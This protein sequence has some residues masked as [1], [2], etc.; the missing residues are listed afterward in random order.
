M[1]FRWTPVSGQAGEEARKAP[2]AP[3]APT[4]KPAAAAS[5]DRQTRRGTCGSRVHHR[6]R[7]TR[8]A[9]H[10]RAGRVGQPRRAA[11]HQGTPGLRR[12]TLLLLRPRERPHR[13]V[14]AIRLQG[15]QGHDA[16]GQHRRLGGVG[17]RLEDRGAIAPGSSRSTTRRRRGRRRRRPSALPA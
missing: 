9:R 4:A 11:R 14:E 12:R 15:S 8:R 17:R 3:T 2:T 6:L 16:G 7:R 10:P 1:K 13:G 5:T